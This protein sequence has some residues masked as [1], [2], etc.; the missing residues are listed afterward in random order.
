M[1]VTAIRH[2]PPGLSVDDLCQPTRRSFL[3]LLAAL[4]GPATSAQDGAESRDKSALRLETMRRWAKEAKVCEITAGKSGP[5][6]P[7][8][9]EPLLR[10]SNP[11]THVVDGTLWR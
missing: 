3:A 2:K 7:L 9:P 10:Y 5:P 11:L 6:L 4:I 1:R 8:R